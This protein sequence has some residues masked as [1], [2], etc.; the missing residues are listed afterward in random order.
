MNISEIINTRMEQIQN[1]HMSIVQDIQKVNKQLQ[2]LHARKIYLE[3]AFYE[4][5]ALQNKLK[6]TSSN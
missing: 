4:L 1:E 6:D 2:D 5:E 3:G